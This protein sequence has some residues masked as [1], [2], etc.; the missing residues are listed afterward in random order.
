E[1]RVQNWNLVLGRMSKRKM[2][3]MHRAKSTDN[4]ANEAPTQKEHRLTYVIRDSNDSK[5]CSIVNSLSVCS[6]PQHD[7]RQKE[8][9]FTGSRD[10]TLKRWEVTTETVF[11]KVNDAVLMGDVLVSCSSDS[12]IKTW[13]A[14]SDGVCTKTF[15][16]H[17]DYVMSLATAK[18]S[19]VVASGGLGGEVFI[20][21][22]EAASVPLVKSK[23]DVANDITYIGS[24]GRL[25]TLGQMDNGHKE[26]V[27]SVAINDIGTVLVSGGT[28][29][30]LRV[31]DP[32][33]GTKSMKLR[34][35]NDNVRALALDVSG[36]FCLS[37][38]SD[39][40]IRLWDLGQ[41]R[42]VHSYAVH[43]DSVW[44][45]AASSSFSYVYSGGRD[46]SVYLTD[47]NSRESL[48]V[49]SEQHPVL[50]L[51]Q[52][53]DDV[54]WVATS[55][56]SVR[57]WPTKSISQ[58]P[59]ASTF[60]AGTL[61]FARAKACLE[62]SS[63][64]PL[65]TEPACVIPINRNIIQH[66]VL[67]DK[68]HILTKDT[69][70]FVKLWEVTSGTV[71]ED[72]GKVSFEDKEDFFQMV[73]VPAW[74]TTDIK[75]GCLSIHLDPPQCFAAEMYAIDI[76]ILGASEDMKINLGQETLRGLFSHWLASREGKTPSVHS[77]SGDLA[78]SCNMVNGN[79]KA[80]TSNGFLLADESHNLVARSSF[81][82]SPNY[83]PSII[84]EGSQ[85]GACRRKLSD[86]HGTEDEKELPT[87]CLECLLH[88]KSTAKEG[89]K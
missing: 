26:S 81:N 34:G 17:T 62:G 5:H 89:T 73:I 77:A 23:D 10:G 36:R 24:I 65:S 48:L 83:P 28:E 86:L 8:T 55:E 35:H 72:F 11:I 30:V 58:K 19:N 85:G 25:G 51:A 50:S 87:W 78:S 59:S 82:F 46:S 31:W 1:G 15:R 43:T 40:M 67:N 69:A 56:A 44:A 47:L 22:L 63:P 42:C 57:K 7:S 38:S 13:Q 4:I 76:S 37:G 33:T 29:K 49:C 6:F 14:F 88:E 9:F 21:D 61:P 75:L 66:T 18:H 41:Q 32:R 20:W 54:L 71:K 3:G 53:V 27:Y 70:G 84:T 12:T 79:G 64:A 45:L 52:H 68:R 74:F 16:Q 60:L 2:S 80:A 39:S